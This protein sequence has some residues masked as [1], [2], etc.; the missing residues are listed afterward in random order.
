MAMN[1]K[2]SYKDFTGMTL[3]TTDPKEWNETEV[4]GSCFAQQNPKTSIFPAG[5]KN[6]KFVKCNLDN[7]T[8]PGT[9]TMEGG[10]NRQIQAQKDGEDWLVDDSL[11]PIEPL[12]KAQFIKL[13]LSTSAAAIPAKESGVSVTEAKRQQLEADLQGQIKALEDAAYWR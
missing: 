8:L 13:G 12:N 5:I 2:Y 1:E 4:I 7:V 6:V 10:I 3:I 11:N 9:C